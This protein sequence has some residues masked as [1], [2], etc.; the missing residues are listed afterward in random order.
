[1]YI[2]LVLILRQQRTYILQPFSLIKSL[3]PTN[4]PIYTKKHKTYTQGDMADYSDNKGTRGGE[5]AHNQ[6]ST[7]IN[8]FNWRSA[9][10]EE[11]T[12]FIK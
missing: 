6:A 7:T 8:I 10:K 5:R 12:T 11:V 1:M 9:L 3:N 2:L 4:P